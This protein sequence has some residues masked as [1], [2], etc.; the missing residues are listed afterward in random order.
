MEVFWTSQHREWKY[1]GKLRNIIMCIYRSIYQ[2]KTCDHFEGIKSRNYV[3][4]KHNISLKCAQTGR[5]SYN[6]PS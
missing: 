5:L 4:A 1:G 6:M 3:V 2:T